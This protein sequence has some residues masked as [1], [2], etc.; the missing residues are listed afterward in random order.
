MVSKNKLGITNQAEL[1]SKK[2]AKQL[3]ETG[4]LFEFEVGTFKGLAAIHQYLFQDIYDFAGKIR[5]VNLA[6]GDFAFAPRMFLDQSLEYLDK[7]PQANF[8]EIVDKYAE[9]NIAHPFREGN[10]RSMRLWLD[11]MLRAKLGRIVDW[12][13]IDKNEYLNA[14]KRSPIST[15]ELKYLLQNNLTDDL[16][17]ESLFKGID[18]SYYYEGYNTYKTED[19][20]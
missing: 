20:D 14:M 4:K 19:L 13:N 5:E 10:G 18:V 11:N 17:K 9:M 8:D 15:G 2:R 3:I 16:S 12:N 6:K 1:L 7:L